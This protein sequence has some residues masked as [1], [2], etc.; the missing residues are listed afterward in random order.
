MMPLLRKF[1]EKIKQL[2]KEYL[3]LF[4][5][6]CLVIFM[7]RSVTSMSQGMPTEITLSTLYPSPFGEYNE[8]RVKRVED[9]E[10]ANYWLDPAGVS[11]LRDINIGIAGQAGARILMDGNNSAIFGNVALPGGGAKAHIK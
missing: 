9:Y 8:L 6:I 10:N 3:F 11:V 2:N 1:L 7:I 4:F 5:I